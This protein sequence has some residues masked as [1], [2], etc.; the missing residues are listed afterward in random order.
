VKRRDATT[1]QVIFEAPAQ[2]MSLNGDGSRLAIASGRIEILAPDA[3][4]ELATLTGDDVEGVV[5]KAVFSGPG[6]VLAV[7]CGQ[8]I[9]LLDVRTGKL[10]KALEGHKHPVLGLALAPDGRTL[11]SGSAFKGK[12]AE[13]EPAK[14]DV[15][16]WD[17]QTGDLLD[18]IEVGESR[19]PG[20]AFSPD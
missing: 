7:A 3:P 11:A 5:G 6:D 18:T 12:P 10:R 16:L 17:I 13:G 19:V 9:Y 4:V 2:A 1:G 20:V 8:K 14:D 15:R